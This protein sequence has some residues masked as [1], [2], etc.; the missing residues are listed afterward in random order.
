[1]EVPVLQYQ[2]EQLMRESKMQETLY[3]LLMQRYELARVNEAR[4]TSSFLVLDAPILPTKKSRPRRTL[5]AIEGLS[6]GVFLGVIF[7]AL[8]RKKRRGPVVGPEASPEHSG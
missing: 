7:A 3:V 4:D 8:S 1:M 5:L 2:L 6:V